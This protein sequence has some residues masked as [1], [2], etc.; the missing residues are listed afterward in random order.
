MVDTVKQGD[1]VDIHFKD[2]CL[3][4]RVVS[5]NGNTIS[6]SFGINNSEDI[7]IVEDI[8]K[9]ICTLMLSV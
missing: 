7:A 1:F 2:G 9:S 5:D 3:I 8:P 6:A 4:G